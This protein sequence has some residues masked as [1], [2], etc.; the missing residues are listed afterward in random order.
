MREM[1]KSSMCPFSSVAQLCLTLRDP[2]DCSTSGLPVPHHLPEFAQVHVHCCSIIYSG[3][4]IYIIY[5][6]VSKGNCWINND[7]SVL[8]NNV[9]CVKSV[10]ACYVQQK[11]NLHLCK[12]ESISIGRCTQGDQ[13]MD[14][15]LGWLYVELWTVSSG[16]HLSSLCLD[17][18]FFVLILFP[19][20]SS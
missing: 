4:Y 1:S 10:F 11:R 3:K 18:T 20:S 8:W 9:F 15:L 14:W 17:S 2:M 13:E 6:F 7:T 12:P 16:E 19:G 5:S